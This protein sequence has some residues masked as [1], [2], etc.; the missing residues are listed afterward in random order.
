MSST[1][2]FTEPIISQKGTILRV[3]PLKCYPLVSKLFSSSSLS[4]PY[5]V[6]VSSAVCLAEASSRNTIIIQLLNRQVWANS[7]DS[8]QTAPRRAV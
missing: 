4:T 1:E 7:A 2:H 3:L 6:S 8:D 5:D